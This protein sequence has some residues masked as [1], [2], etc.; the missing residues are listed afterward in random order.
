[1]ISPVVVQAALLS[2]SSPI[3]LNALCCRLQKLQTAVMC[4]PPASCVVRLAQSLGFS[5]FRE[6]HRLYQQGF[7][8]K[9]S[10]KHGH[11]V[12]SSSGISPLRIG[13]ICDA[14]ASFN[15][16]TRRAIA[17]A[18]INQTIVSIT[19]EYYVSHEIDEQGYAHKILSIAEQC[20]ALILVAREHP[21]ISQ[22]VNDVIRADKPIVCLTTDLPNTLRTAYIGSDQ[23]SAGATAA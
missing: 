17:S 22:A 18:Q 5:G 23:L 21:I 15:M 11:A 14:G 12:P 2:F 1:M 13:V 19:G 7:S 20:D 6:M 4:M 10:S 9:P 16:A 3:Q 8:P